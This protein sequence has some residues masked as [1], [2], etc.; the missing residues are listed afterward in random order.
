MLSIKLF[1]DNLL[2]QSIT[3]LHL[4]ILFQ[5]EMIIFFKWLMSLNLKFIE[6]IHDFEPA[7]F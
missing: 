3:H 1:I 5:N 6:M 7:F 2:Y 4:L